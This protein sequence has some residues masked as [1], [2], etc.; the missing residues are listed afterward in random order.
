MMHTLLIAFFAAASTA[1]LAPAALAS[2]PTS[3]QDL[4][5]RADDRNPELI[6][7]RAE[8][9]ELR[10]ASQRSKTVPRG[11]VGLNEARLEQ[12]RTEVAVKVRIAFSRV[13]AARELLNGAD[14][15]LAALEQVISIA[16]Q[17]QATNRA[18]HDIARVAFIRSSQERAM[19]ERQ[20]GEAST[21]M[22]WLVGAQPK[23]TVNVRGSILEASTLADEPADALVK[24]ALASRADLKGALR[25]YDG[26]LGPPQSASE[27][28]EHEARVRRASRMVSAVEAAIHVDV[29]TSIARVHVARRAVTAFALKD[30]LPGEGERAGYLV[31]LREGKLRVSE[32]AIAIRDLAEAERQRVSDLTELAAADADLLRA[33]GSR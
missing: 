11:N 18:E 16:E 21:E 12:R 5:Q 10:S 19:A 27:T 13:L 26:A 30:F 6:A 15:T 1:L 2:S 23:E 28:M 25:E 31:A 33:I 20:F 17:R 14:R 4:L 22:L 7:V 32:A 8:L 29:V 9:A 24:R 3:L